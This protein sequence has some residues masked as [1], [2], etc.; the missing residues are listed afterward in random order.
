[1]ARPVHVI[2]VTLGNDHWARSCFH[3]YGLLLLAHLPH[4]DDLWANTHA[5]V[6]LIVAIAALLNGAQR[7][8]VS[9]RTV[10][11]AQPLAA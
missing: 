5:Q 7:L 2:F 3:V 8:R 9:Q 11:P 6:V 10:M 4:A 1:M